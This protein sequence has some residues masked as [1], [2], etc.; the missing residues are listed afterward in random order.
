M[1][2]ELQAGW[3]RAKDAMEY[4][5]NALLT[6][7]EYDDKLGQGRCHELLAR[8]MEKRGRSLAALSH[9]QSA[10]DIFLNACDRER[11]AKAAMKV[12]ALSA[13]PGQKGGQQAAELA[14]RLAVSVGN[15]TM[16]L[17]AERFGK[18][19]AAKEN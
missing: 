3:G 8:L 15:K 12:A 7:E 13:Q 16:A 19:S 1:M 18:R 6:A 4:A 10:L 5:Q 17:K 2:A 14:W 11:A 9:W